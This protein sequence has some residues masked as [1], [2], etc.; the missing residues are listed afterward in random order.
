MST[1]K[2]IETY[3]IIK[4]VRSYSGLIDKTRYAVGAK[5]E[6][7]AIKILRDKIGLGKIAVYY[8]EREP[9]MK[10]KEVGEFTGEFDNR[11][12]HIYKIL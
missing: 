1:I 4:S 5:S 10:Y 3:I 7:E 2:S 12:K 9:I 8:K 11:G 6:K